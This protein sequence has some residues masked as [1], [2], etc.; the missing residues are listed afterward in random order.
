MACC[1]VYIV[2]DLLD[3]GVG[4][5][6]KGAELMS[7]VSIDSIMPSALPSDGIRDNLFLCFMVCLE[8]TGRAE[9]GLIVSKTQSSSFVGACI[10]RLEMSVSMVSGIRSAL[11]T[12][13]PRSI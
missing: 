7:R 3:E 8:I 9:L 13:S 5:P 1:G 12:E 6:V 10:G 11:R 4:E 2:D